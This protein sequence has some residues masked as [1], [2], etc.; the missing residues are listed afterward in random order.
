MKVV[1]RE[2]CAG[3]SSYIKTFEIC[4]MKTIIMNPKALEQEEQYKSQSLYWENN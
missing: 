2:K 1:L 3:L 4:Q